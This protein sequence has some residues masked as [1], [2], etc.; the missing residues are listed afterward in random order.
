MLVLN[1][2]RPLA[3]PWADA[4]VPAIV[5]VRELKVVMLLLRYYMVITIQVENYL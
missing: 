5:E 2:G 4:H 1:N 3:I